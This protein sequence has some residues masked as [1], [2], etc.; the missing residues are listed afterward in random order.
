MTRG[1]SAMGSC[2]RESEREQRDVRHR[3]KKGGIERAGSR[4]RPGPRVADDEVAR[5]RSARALLL[6][7]R[8]RRR[9]GEVVDGLDRW[10]AVVGSR[11]GLECWL[12][13]K[14]IWEDPEEDETG[15]VAAVAGQ[16]RIPRK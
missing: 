2:G 11:G 5:W 4:G 15:G 6:A 7:M 13:E 16:G 8:S 9:R 10:P 3:K 1:S 14:G 12:G